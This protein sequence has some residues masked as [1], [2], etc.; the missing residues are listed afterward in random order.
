MPKS[1]WGWL[2]IVPLAFGAAGLLIHPADRQRTEVPSTQALIST[3]QPATPEVA[4][5]VPEGQRLTAKTVFVSADSLNVRS[6]PSTTASVLLKLRRGDAVVPTYRSGA[7][8]G[9]SLS[10]GSLGWVHGHYLVERAPSGPAD[11]IG[12]VPDATASVPSYDRDEIVQAIIAASLASY[13]GRCPCPYNTMRNGRQCGGNS[14]Y[15]KPGGRAPLCYPTDVTDRMVA[16]Y[17][18]RQ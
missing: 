10:N 16:D 5:T 1:R 17:V 12:P 6:S 8:F 7:W 4:P 14:A 15:R 18:S 9:L 2:W 11:L 3:P 13:S